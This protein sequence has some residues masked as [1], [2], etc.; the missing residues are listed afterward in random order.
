M[1]A[2]AFF[3]QVG[4]AALI[5]QKVRQITDVHE[6]ELILHGI[7]IASEVRRRVF[8]KDKKD[9]DTKQLYTVEALAHFGTKYPS[10]E[11]RD[12]IE[13]LQAELTAA[14]DDEGKARL[15]YSQLSEHSHP[16]LFSVVHSYTKGVPPTVTSAGLLSNDQVRVGL[17][18]WTLALSMLLHCLWQEQT[19]GQSTKTSAL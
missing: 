8:K 4:H 17:V 9:I 16:T 10:L 15:L 12:L 2:R 14:G 5:R 6:L 11:P 1:L 7:D 18:S 19:T 13:A 3:E